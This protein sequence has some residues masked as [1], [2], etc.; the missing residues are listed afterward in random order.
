MISLLYKPEQL[1]IAS[2]RRFEKNVGICLWVRDWHIVSVLRVSFSH[3]YGGERYKKKEEFQR[4]LRRC[5][6]TN[7]RSFV[8]WSG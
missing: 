6:I 4:N 7:D 8:E 3:S 1:N 5:R 2:D